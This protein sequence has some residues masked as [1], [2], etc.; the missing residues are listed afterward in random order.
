MILGLFG[1]CNKPFCFGEAIRN[2]FCYKHYWKDW[3]EK[4]VMN[5][6]TIGG[7]HREIEGGLNIPIQSYESLF[8]E[9]DKLLQD[10]A[11]MLGLKGKDREDFFR[12]NGGRQ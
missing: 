2:G 7:V 4:R 10:K 12:L 1:T 3:N 9:Q 6:T 5:F 11:N 8:Q